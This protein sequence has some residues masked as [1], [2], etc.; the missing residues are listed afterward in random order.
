M[1]IQNN[2][3]PVMN[4][5]TL[6]TVR[7]MGLL[8]KNSKIDSVSVITNNRVQLV[9]INAV[10]VNQFGEIQIKNLGLSMTTDFT[11]KLSTSVINTIVPVI[12]ELDLNDPY[13]RVD[14]HLEQGASQTECL[15]R[16]CAWVRFYSIKNN[17]F[18]F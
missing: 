5:L 15:R 9:E 12:E 3:A 6:N 7:I 13:L 18:V 8:S 2:N 11:I 16:G 14:C 10:N 4:G 17:F 1:Q